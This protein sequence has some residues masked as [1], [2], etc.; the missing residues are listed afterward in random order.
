[1]RS[2][3]LRLIDANLNRSQEGLRVCE[4]IVRFL[5]YD[6]SLTEAFK[7]QRHRL[8]SLSK[9]ISPRYE[10]LKARRSRGDVGKVS[11]RSEKRRKDFYE[12][13]RANIQRA[14]ESSRVL[15][16]VSKIHDRDL[17]DNFKNLRFKIYELEKKS[18]SK[19]KTLRDSK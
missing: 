4:D 17:S 2:S 16:E 10:M 6:K 1:M 9:K 5:V 15:E 3:Y 18:F 7:R 19:I 12:V 14:E 13:F 8:K 11:S